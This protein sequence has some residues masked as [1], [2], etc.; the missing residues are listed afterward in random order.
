MPGLVDVLCGHPEYSLCARRS[1]LLL[2]CDGAVHVYEPVAWHKSLGVMSDPVLCSCACSEQPCGV[3]RVRKARA[4]P[5]SQAP[6]RAHT[7]PGQHHHPGIM[8]KSGIPA[9]QMQRTD[10]RERACGSGTGQNPLAEHAQHA[11]QPRSIAWGG[12]G[13]AAMKGGAP[14]FLREA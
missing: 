3:E 7:Q 10:A 12:G 4:H 11:P 9:Q 8:Q 2:F 5:Y 14:C 1:I 6:P 13:E